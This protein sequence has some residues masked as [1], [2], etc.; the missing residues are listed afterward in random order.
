[1]VCEGE[2]VYAWAALQ[3]GGFGVYNYFLPSV[4]YTPPSLTDSSCLTLGDNLKPT[5]IGGASP[6]FLGRRDTSKGLSVTADESQVHWIH[7]STSLEAKALVLMN[8]N[9]FR[10]V[11][12][13]PCRDGN[14]LTGLG[15][16]NSVHGQ[17]HGSW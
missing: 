16:H 17:V 13:D 3:F 12:L 6:T 11:G 7:P 8:Y 14:A 10:K 2:C 1:M 9:Y 5:G 4:L 15:L